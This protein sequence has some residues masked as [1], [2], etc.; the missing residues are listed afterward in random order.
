MANAN[1]AVSLA[2]NGGVNPET[3]GAAIVNRTA[4]AVQV[5]SGYAYTAGTVDVTDFSVIV[6]S[7]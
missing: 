1:Y 5:K 2:V 3:F 6:F 4:S 7:L